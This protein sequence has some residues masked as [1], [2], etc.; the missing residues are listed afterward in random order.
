MPIITLEEV[1]QCLLDEKTALLEFIV[2]ETKI[3]SFIIT[4]ERNKPKLYVHS[5]NVDVSKSVEESS[6]QFPRTNL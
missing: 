5:L 2:T 6:E 1:G 4:S 3:F